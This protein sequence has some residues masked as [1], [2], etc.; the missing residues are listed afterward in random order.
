M[1][2]RKTAE[3]PTIDLPALLATERADIEPMVAESGKSYDR[4]VS[5]LR[6]AV[7]EAPDLL[8]CSP[9]SLTREI[10]KC[11]VDGLVP[12]GK[13]AVL[14]PYWNKD[15]GCHEANYQ[16][17]VHGVIKRL[18]ELGDVF[19]IVCECV[20]SNDTFSINLADL[21]SLSHE[22]DVFAEN[23]GDIVGAYVIFRDDERRVIHREWVPLSE[24]TKAR[25]ASKSPNSPAWKTWE[26]EM[27]RK[28]TL[29][30]GSKYISTDNEKI[31]ALLERTDSMFDFAS[32]KPAA[33]R[34][35]PF[36]GGNVIEG[37]TGPDQDVEHST[38]K[39]ANNSKAT[40]ETPQGPKPWQLRIPDTE[41]PTVCEIIRKAVKLILD[42]QID[43]P[44]RRGVL[45]GAVPGWKTDFPEHLHPLL[46][47]IVGFCDNALK[48]MHEKKNWMVP[49]TANLQKISKQTGEDFT[50]MLP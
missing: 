26:S 32:V 47:H 16:P 7:Q 38:D 1:S 31:R 5:T 14:I 4:L 36:G 25:Q 34:E 50:E 28:V 3:R 44:D 22:P 30:R 24:L 9:E 45:K 46:A 29:R 27:F 39:P 20:H 48:A 23:R 19:S 18:K 2:N 17:M 40:G 8:K 21:E 49:L 37:N 15:A 41:L 43:I 35:D 12:D 42:D 6:I 33:R 11:A 13:E 10:T